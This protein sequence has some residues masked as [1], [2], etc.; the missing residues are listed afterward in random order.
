MGV[1]KKNFGYKIFPIK[2]FD[3]IVNTQFDTLNDKLDMNFDMEYAGLD[4]KSTIFITHHRL[5]Y[6]YLE[7]YK[8]VRV[9]C[10]PDS[11]SQ[12][13]YDKDKT[14][15][16][17]HLEGYS[18]KN[19]K[20]DGLLRWLDIDLNFWY[21]KSFAPNKNTFLVKKLLSYMKDDAQK[22][23]EFNLTQVS[24]MSHFGFQNIDN[25]AGMAGF[26]PDQDKS[27]ISLQRSVWSDSD[28]FVSFDQVTAQTIFASLCGAKTI[29]IPSKNLW[30]PEYYNPEEFRH[31]FY[32]YASPGIAYVLDDLDYMHKTKSL[33]RTHI[34]ES[35]KIYKDDIKKFVNI[36][37]EKF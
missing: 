1:G 2:N 32:P 33:I 4:P 25:L 28:Y 20:F 21:P 18:T 5:E 11:L 30:N 10:D 24:K 34:R 14:L 31:L 35:K 36:C 17:Y 37:Y 13:P 3:P 22:H 23:I 29:I 8:S 27:L 12:A 26:T 7:K 16:F 19:F 9:I 6:P 15:F